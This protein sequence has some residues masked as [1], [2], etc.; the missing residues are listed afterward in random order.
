[1]TPFLIL[2]YEMIK[3]LHE[4][5]NM[6]TEAKGRKSFLHHHLASGTH[7]AIIDV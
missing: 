7:F 2:Q 1:M 3:L 6:T 5:I 4:K